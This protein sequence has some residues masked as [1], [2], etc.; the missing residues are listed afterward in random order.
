M[1][2]LITLALA[3]S[4]ISGLTAKGQ[5]KGWKF[6]MTKE[7]VQQVKEC[8]PYKPVKATGGVECPALKFD[9]LTVNVSFIFKPNLD[10]IQI[11][12]YE[13]KDRREAATRLHKLLGWLKKHYGA[14]ESPALSKPDAM[15]KETLEKKLTA[16]VEASAGKMVKWQF[17]P[18]KN[19]V[20]AFVFSSLLYHPQHGYY[21]FLYFK[22]PK[23]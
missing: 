11:W 19:P 4:L 14:V 23:Q 7:Q 18:A 13:G 20:D 21:V 22:P 10:K 17:K 12:F 8:T 9:D 5:F 15:S 16:A 6:G 1:T 2:R 3:L